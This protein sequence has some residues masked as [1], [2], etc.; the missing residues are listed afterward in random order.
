MERS[1]QL[2][3]M[4]WLCIHSYVLYSV[5]ND[6]QKGLNKKKKKNQETSLSE[7]T[8]KMALVVI[9]TG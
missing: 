9:Q 4:I 2:L 1:E 7:P 5:V 8:L 3:E 6:K